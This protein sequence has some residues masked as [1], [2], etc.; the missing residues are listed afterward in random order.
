MRAG[1]GRSILLPSAGAACTALLFAL[2]PA[3]AASLNLIDSSLYATI[4]GAEVETLTSSYD[5]TVDGVDGTITSTVYEGSATASGYFVYTYQIELYDSSTSSIDAVMFEFGSTPPVI[6]MIGDAFTVDDGSANVAPTSAFYI[7]TS[8][9]AGF[10]FEFNLA[11][12]ETSLEF[13]L[14]S[15]IAPTTTEAELSGVTRSARR[16]SGRR[17]SG[18]S[19]STAAAATVLSNGAAPVP[20]PNAA[21]LF[22]IGFATIAACCRSRASRA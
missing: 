15:A 6:D 9:T 2:T 8:E 11:A 17:R 22:S 5:F 3:S 7:E 18:R 4:L 12:G 19:S 1:H 10:E 14:F 13:G 21:L 20:E 16:R